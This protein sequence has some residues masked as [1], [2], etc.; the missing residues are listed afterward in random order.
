MR[1]G[2]MRLRRRARASARLE[3]WGQEAWDAD[4]SQREAGDERKEKLEAGRPRKPKPAAEDPDCTQPSKLKR[5][6]ACLHGKAENADENSSGKDEE[7]GK[8]DVATADS[9]RTAAVKAT[10][11]FAGALGLTGV[12]V[13]VG[14]AILWIRF[15]EAHIP[16]IQAISVQPKLEALAQGGEQTGTFLLIALGALLLIY[17]ADPDGIVRGT[18]AV[19]LVLLSCGATIWALQTN[20]PW[21][22]SGSLTVLAFLLA[23]G[24]AGVGLRTETRFWPMGVAVFISALVFSSSAAIMIAQDQTLV[25]AVAVLRGGLAQ[26]TANGEVDAE[27]G[28]AEKPKT[29]A[30]GLAGIYVAATDDTLYIA[31]SVTG[32]GSPAMAMMDIPRAGAA[33]AVGPLESVADARARGPALLARLKTSRD[34][35]VAVSEK[36]EGQDEGDGNGGDATTGS[37]SGKGVAAKGPSVGK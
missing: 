27:S 21:W 13:G 35:N 31:K 9:L 12:L 18:T 20:L 2:Y 6:C 14:A 7:A 3:R 33:Y 29:R 10:S 1:A 28:G 15:T 17:L 19:A 23:Y 11:A 4:E 25:Q 5:V 16:A 37:A 22:Y 36:E 34:R 26:A 8:E 24:C 30:E 32:R